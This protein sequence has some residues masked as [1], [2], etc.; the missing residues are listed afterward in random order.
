VAVV[1]VTVLAEEVVIEEG[2]EALTTPC[3]SHQRDVDEEVGHS[4]LHVAVVGE[5]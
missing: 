2:T 1:A 5:D 4:D 3:R